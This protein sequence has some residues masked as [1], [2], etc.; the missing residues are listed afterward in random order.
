MG[1]GKK[2]FKC[3]ICNA[4]FGQR[5]SLNK[6]VTT[7]H[8]GKKQ[9][10]CKICSAVFGEKGNLKKHVATV[11]EGNKQFKCKMCKAS[12]GEKGNLKRHITTVHERKKS[13][14]RD[15]PNTDWTETLMTNTESEEKQND[16]DFENIK[17]VLEVT[18]KEE[19]DSDYDPNEGIE[20]DQ[21]E[22]WIKYL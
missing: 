2:Q 21:D 15:I 13:L 4:E 19:H 1:E 10:K 14:K 8:E 22:D 20:N 7:V 3:H 18:I 12:F 11:H 17:S 16:D 9:F 5:G 6:H